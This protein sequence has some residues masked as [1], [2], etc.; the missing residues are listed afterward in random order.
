MKK[1]ERLDIERH[2]KEYINLARMLKN[3]KEM[4]DLTY[5]FNALDMIEKKKKFDAG[6]EAG[7]TKTQA[8]ELCK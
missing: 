3:Y 7:F 5:E 6:I 1:V 2:S 8:L 4:K